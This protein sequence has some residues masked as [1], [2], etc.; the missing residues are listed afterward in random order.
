MSRSP[1]LLANRKPTEAGGRLLDGPVEQT[2]KTTCLEASGEGR[3]SPAPHRLWAERMLLVALIALFV[4]KGLV[5]GWR[6]LNSDFPNYYLV[7]RLYRAGYPLERVYDWTWLQR[8]KDHQGIDQG[9]V[10]FIPST[11]P[12]AL[13]VAAWSSLPPLAAKHHWLVVNLALLPLICFLLFRISR[14]RWEQVAILVFLA[15]IPLRDNFLLGQVHLLVLML[16]ALAAWLFFRGSRFLSG[17]SLACAAALKIYPGLFLT[18]FLWKR[19]WRAAAGL[20][21]GLIMVALGSIYLFGSDACV[22]Y[23]R[24]VLPAGLRGETLDPYNP[25]WNSWTALVRRLFIA[26]PELNPAPV[27]HL[28]LLYAVLQPLIHA[29]IFAVFMWAIGSEERGTAKTKI[30]WAAFVFLLLFLSPQPGPYHFVALI[31]TAILIV[32][33]S[34]SQRR[35]ILAGVAVATYALICAPILRNPWAQ[36]AGWNNLL[37]FPRLA[38]MTLFA[39]LLLRMLFQ[40]DVQSATK[41]LNARNTAIATS[42]LILLSIAGFISTQRHLRHQFENYNTRVAIMPGNLLA[43]D[44]TVIPGGILLTRMTA[45]GYTIAWLQDK[46]VQDVS[47]L[48][49]DWLHPAYSREQNSVWAEQSDRKGSQ[50]VR[51][52][53]G[54]SGKADSVTQEVGD[55]QEPVV[56]RD[57]RFIAFLRPIKGRNSLWIKKNGGTVS[58]DTAAGQTEVAGEEYDVREAEFLPDDQ[59]IFSSSRNGAARLYRTTQSGKIKWLPQPA[60]AARSPRISP[61]GKWL[62]FACEQGGSTQIH[63]AGL[64][65]NH[66]EQ[67]TAG[68]CTST[69][70]A[71]TT[72]SKSLVYVTDCGRGLGLTALAR[73]TVFP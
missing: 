60:C 19:Q 14:L 17:I 11:L 58:P 48:N 2:S 50:I 13:V 57:A 34:L 73:A 43:C 30:E 23:V 64:E 27:A 59:L 18:Y 38:L 63:V 51:F 15:F 49:G 70:P 25:A 26:E 44:P 31:L 5:P 3:G 36:P 40:A 41:R 45:S 7:A 4:V 24:Q 54:V 33:Y 72:D 55:A 8:Q 37:F 10:S 16:L 65:G 67:L 20:V 28:P 1:S 56:S 53:M 22:L 21:I 39:I 6:H 69:S 61:D 29:F 52:S 46:R 9:L 42:A 66:E 12:S 47:G 32:D 68:D 71:W 35:T 62:A